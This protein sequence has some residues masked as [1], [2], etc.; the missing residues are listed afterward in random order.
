[1]SFVY[2]NK[3]LIMLP[4]ELIKKLM[5]EV[6]LSFERDE[7]IKLTMDGSHITFKEDE[8]NSMLNFTIRQKLHIRI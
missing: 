8:K 2:G 3:G 7:P 6:V 1:V 5:N 4:K